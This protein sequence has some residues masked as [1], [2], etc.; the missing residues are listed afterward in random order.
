MGIEVKKVT[1]RRGLREFVRVPHVVLGNNPYWVPPLMRDEIAALDP[2]INP[3]YEHADSRLFIAYR[4]SRPAGCVAAIVSHAA[5]EKYGEKNLR[6][7]WFDVVDDYEVAEALLDS[8]V[9]TARD[10]NLTTITGPLGF[11][12][13]D[14]EGMLVEGFDVLS[15]I[16]TKYSPP[17]YRDFMERY[18]FVKDVD[19]VEFKIPKST[20]GLYDRV[21]RV[22]DRLIERGGFKVRRYDRKKDMMKRGREVFELFNDA[23][24]GLY[25]TVP[26]TERQIEYYLK[27]Y[28]SFIR[29]DLTFIF[30][31]PDG[32]LGGVFITMPSLSRAFQKARGR[33]LPFG[34]LHIL[35]ALQKKEVID[36]YIIGVAEPYRQSGAG[37]I[38]VS[39]LCRAV[40]NSELKY[41]DTSQILEYNKD[42]QS[43]FKVFPQERHRRRRVYK[44]AL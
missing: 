10:M 1:T 35:K 41:A 34:W 16:T 2:R 44:L 19:Y 17:Y 36:F 39:E 24:D 7:G 38:L 13:L 12:D 32:R 29:K 28:W 33:L 23:F 20:Q 40:G 26:L 15:P 3:A 30:D 43:M 27:R 6:F 42:V 18:G 8:L 21:H 25:G 14:P 31:G 37:I 22:A 9:A 5:N 11:S 4:D